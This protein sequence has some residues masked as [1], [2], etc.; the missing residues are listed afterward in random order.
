MN[1]NVLTKE[2]KSLVL[3][4]AREVRIISSASIV[5]R[6]E[7]DGVLGD[8]F[9]TSDTK[10][11]RF[12]MESWEAAEAEMQRLALNKAL[13]GMSTKSAD[14]DVILA[15][16]LINQCVSSA[17]G[18]SIFDYPFLGLFGACSTA[19][20]GLLLASLLCGQS[21]DR[22]A[23]VTSSH[24]C[25]AERQFRFPLEYA[26]Q[27]TPTSQW[28]VTGSG[29]FIV[30]GNKCDFNEDNNIRISEVKIGK[31]I[32]KGITDAN[33]MGAAMAPSAAYTIKSYLDETGK[34][35]DD[36]DMILTGDLGAEG[37]AILIDLLKAGGHDISAVHSDCGLLI[38]D[39]ER[40]DKKAG[41]SGCGCSASVLASYIIPQMKKGIWKDILFV[42]T[43]AL[44]NTMTSQ[45]GMSIP[46]IAHLVRLTL[47]E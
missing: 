32:D 29:A 41:G 46:G 3:T 35:P 42:G 25:S 40:Q 15:G 31:T 23:A 14:L 37:S 47:A 28:T 4:P 2:K 43:G 8:F 22:A 12:G 11:D 18:L 33:N 1:E 36:F 45:Q 5:G 34:S 44:M 24:N 20:E 30:S 16:D 10:D 19:A 39:R 9:D 27:R 6:E 21:I 7:K 26:A 13:S 17:F 38:Y